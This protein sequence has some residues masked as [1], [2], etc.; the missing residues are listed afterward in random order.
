MCPLPVVS[1]ASTTLPAGSRRTSP[2]LVSNSTSPVSQEYKQTLRRIVPIHFPHTRR[3]VADIVPR[4]WK[5]LRK[6][7]RGIVLKKLS[8][9]Q[10][11][12][13][14]GR[15]RRRDFMLV[16]SPFQFEDAAAVPR[17]GDKALQAIVDLAHA[18]TLIGVP[19][20]KDNEVIGAIGIFFYDERPFTEKQ[21][22]L[23]KN[24]AAQAVIA[25]E[26]TRLL[27]ERRQRTG[28]LSEALEQQTATSDVRK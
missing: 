20:L 22:E 9:L 10:C 1:S 3:D 2:S 17:Y 23:V 8:W 13:L 11:L 24:F 15:M 28:D 6:A 12:S 16:V 19:M 5:V 26:N 25:I 18:R 14:G 27:S 4:S 21:I 7:Q